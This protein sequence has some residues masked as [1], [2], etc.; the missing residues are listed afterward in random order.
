MQQRTMSV[1]AIILTLALQ[2]QTK[3]LHTLDHNS[4][5][6]VSNI[7]YEP[8]MLISMMLIFIIAALMV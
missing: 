1:I 4:G 5:S 3:A 6:L 8:S 2:A 7:L